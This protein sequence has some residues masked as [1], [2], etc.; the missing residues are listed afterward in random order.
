MPV[1]VLGSYAHGDETILLGSL[2]HWVVADCQWKQYSGYHWYTAPYVPMIQEFL[3]ETV[4]EQLVNCSEWILS[5][6]VSLSK[7]PNLKCKQMFS[8]LESSLTA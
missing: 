2:K 6:Q 5:G 7:E 3:T 1:F 4:G 8:E